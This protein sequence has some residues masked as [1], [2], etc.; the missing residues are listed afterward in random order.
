MPQIWIVSDGK[1]GHRNQ[2][3]GLYAALKQQRPELELQEIAPLSTTQSLLALLFRQRPQP[4]LQP[5]I[6][7]PPVLLIGAGHAT[8]LTLLALKRLTGAPAVVLMKPSLPLRWFDLCLIPEHDN[9]APAANILTTRGALNLMRSGTKQPGSGMI[10]IGGPSK[11]FGWDEAALLAQLQQ[12]LSLDARLWCMTTS[13]RT[14]E[15]T[16]SLLRKLPGVELV[17]AEETPAGWLPEKLASAEC[18]WV[19]ED[20]VSMVYEALTAGCAVGTLELP[21]GRGGRLA[22]G[23]KRLAD[24]GLIQPFSRWREGSDRTLSTP[25]STSASTHTF[26][27]AQRCAGWLLERGWL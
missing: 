11:H 23:L 13:R 22:G 17:P 16:L 7:T 2:S 14:P 20:S 1:P 9:P 19:T 4:L 5:L 3:L 6:Q 15:S 27:E 21:A 24:D 25:A 26:N 8:H 12:L 18:C 10:L